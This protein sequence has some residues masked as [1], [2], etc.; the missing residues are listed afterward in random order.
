LAIALNAEGIGLHEADTV[1]F[2]ARNVDES[3]TIGIAK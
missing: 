2:S 3:Q 1:A